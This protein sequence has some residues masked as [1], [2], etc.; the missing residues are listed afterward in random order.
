MGIEENEIAREEGA[1]REQSESL[2]QETEEA[3]E[4]SK[5]DEANRWNLHLHRC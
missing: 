1:K 3:K 5:T 4:G 2:E